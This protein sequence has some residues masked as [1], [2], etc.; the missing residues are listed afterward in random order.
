MIEEG[1]VEFVVKFFEYEVLI[2]VFYVCWYE[3]IG[4]VFEEGVVFVDW[5]D[6]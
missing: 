6:V 1:M 5:L 4:G 2:C 3:M